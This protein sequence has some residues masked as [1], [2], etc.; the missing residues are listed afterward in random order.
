[1]S[2]S[3]TNRQS[4]LKNPYRAARQWVYLQNHDLIMTGRSDVQH[5]RAAGVAAVAVDFHSLGLPRLLHS[6]CLA[7]KKADRRG[8]LRCTS[9]INGWYSYFTESK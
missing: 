9:R 8:D 2:K 4:T 7:L 5:P 1:V 6:W 3:L